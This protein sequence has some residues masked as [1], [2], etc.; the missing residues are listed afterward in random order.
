[1]RCAAT[2]LIVTVLLTGVPS[3]AWAQADAKAAFDAGKAAYAK[4]DF[5][6]AREQFEGA[7]KTDVRNPEAFLWLGR[8]HY[9]LG[10]LD[11]AV[12]AWTRALALAPKHPYAT[13][14]LKAL[15]GQR[16]E[17]RLQHERVV[18][19]RGEQRLL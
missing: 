4:G 2:F 3:A 10:E 7:S 12:A 19:D 17:V 8:S 6:K 9:Q 14:M 18:D 13:K 16:V 15:R 5:E 11:K 1:M